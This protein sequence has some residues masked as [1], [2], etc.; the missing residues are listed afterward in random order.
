MTNRVRGKTT[1]RFVQLSDRKEF[2]HSLTERLQFAGHIA[3]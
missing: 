1:N 2:E 3:V